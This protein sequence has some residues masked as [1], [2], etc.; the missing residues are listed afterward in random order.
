MEIL[1]AVI[2]VVVAVL[3]AAL[4]TFVFLAL[5]TKR[6]ALDA[7]RRVPRIGKMMEIDGNRIHYIDEGEGQPILFIHGLGAQ[8][9][10]FRQPLF[11]RFPDGFRLIAL[12]RPG[13]GYSR[14]ARGTGGTLT[15]Q[16]AAIRRFIETLKLERPLLVGHSLGGAIALATAILHPDSISG[17]ALLSP[18][19]HTGGKVPP[20]LEPLYIR[21]PF[22][23][24]LTAWTIAVPMARK[25]AAETLAFIFAPQSAPDDYMTEGGGSLGL[26]PSHFYGTS[27]DFVDVR[28]DAGELEKR[29]G[30]IV[31]P[32]GILFGTADR[33][34]DYQLHGLG[35]NGRIAGIE[36]ELAEGVGHMPQYAEP[37]K[38]VD[39]IRRMAAKAAVSR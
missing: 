17:L 30:E 37:E 15:E 10:Q 23:R 33:V 22:R 26:R 28:R 11:H 38:V 35:M 25:Y 16:A 6:I 7:E 14:R 4:I 32:V 29:Y 5:A 18:H 39:F 24:W 13:S 27:T 21:S 3:V 1:I 9:H 31:M 2:G 8:L 20:E 36:I 12:D 19:T 34:I